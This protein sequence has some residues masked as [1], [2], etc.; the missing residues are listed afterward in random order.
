MSVC[1]VRDFVAIDLETTGL[2]FSNEEILELGAVLFRDGVEAGSFSAVLR[3]KRPVSPFIEALT[4]ITAAEAEAGQDPVESLN[5]FQEFCGS[6]PLVAHNSMFDLRFLR[7][8]W[9]A[10]GIAEPARAVFDT[11]LGARTVWPEWPSHKLETLVERLGLTESGDTSHRAAADARSAGRLFLAVQTEL[12]RL[13][14]TDRA[15]VDGLAWILRD[16]ASAWESILAWDGGHQAPE[17]R[18]RE[19]EEDGFR[20]GPP[21]EAK[22]DGRVVDRVFSPNGPLAKGR[23]GWEPRPAQGQMARE[24]AQAF[25]D[26]HFLLCE[27]GTGTG[28]SLAYLAP[29]ALWAVEA[30]DRVVVST[31]TKTL[32]NQLVE[33]EAPLVREVVPEARIVVLKGRSNYLCV[34]RYAEHLEDAARLDASER[35][36]FLPLVV[37]VSRTSTGD[38][39]ECNGFGRD[40][41]AGLWAK[42]QSDGRAAIPG[43]HPLFKR[44][45]HQRAKRRA[46]SAHVVIVNHA[47]LLSDLSIDFALLPSYERLILDEAHHLADAAHDHLGRVVSLNRLR[48]A[49][50]PLAE[51]G[52]KRAGLLGALSSVKDL[53][54]TAIPFVDRCREEL[55]NADR[56]LHRLFQKLGEKIGRRG[57]EQKLRLREPLA[58]ETGVDPSPAQG[59]F[60]AALV[61]IADLRKELAGWDAAEERGYLSDL[62]AVEGAL[63]EIRRDFQAL[64]DAAPEADVHWIEDWS[65]PIRLQL[66]ASPRDPGQLLANKLYPVLKTCVFTSATLAVRGRPEYFEFRS[67]IARLDRDVRRVRHLSPFKMRE[68]ARVVAAGWLPKPG[69]KGWLDSVV[70][71]LREVVLPLNRRALVLFTSERN[72]RDVREKLAMEWK[73]AGRLMLAQGVDGNREALL[74]MF[75]KHDGACLLGADSFWEGVDLPGRD[76]E[77]VV[78]ARLPFPVPSDPL[79]ASRAEEVEAEGRPPFAECFLPEAWLKLRQGIGRLLR[80]SDDRGAILVLD[81]RIVRERYGSYLADAWDG[82]HRQAKTSDQALRE[83]REWFEGPVEVAEV[84]NDLGT[85]ANP[86][87]EGDS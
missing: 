3:T 46:E 57:E 70:Q 26:G 65:N 37:W 6:L 41:N 34:R 13:H 47:L 44:C 8:A 67:G 18:W 10:A 78:V 51:S 1:P 71:T 33:R 74:Q 19:P 48:R 86:P 39:E 27:A 22:L 43:R 73:Q 69:E 66:R 17:P 31:A 20:P 49:V 55:A 50:H 32:Q 52:D 61:A 83:L 81:S 15:V 75:R 84:E 7:K 59:A 5:A 25:S 35:E 2:D 82:G 42:L 38:I 56:R 60:D 76:L 40:R 87:I 14:E 68:Q 24:V 9:E 80:R 4:G 30:K 21:R 45:F 62:S 16:S 79:V 72:L 11:L 36:A 63:G 53:P 23:E 29:A 12:A 77:L 54:V 85:A 64:C 28:K 58:N